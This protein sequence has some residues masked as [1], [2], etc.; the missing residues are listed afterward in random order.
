MANTKTVKV[1][2]QLDR[3]KIRYMGV[4]ILF[5]ELKSLSWK[6]KTLILILA[7]V[8]TLDTLILDYGVN[9]GHK[10]EWLWQTSYDEQSWHGWS[11]GFY[12]YWYVSKVT[13]GA[14]AF[15]GVLNVILIS[16]RKISNY[17]WG[18]L[19]CIFY[20]NYAFAAGY[21]GD[22]L[23]NI[24]FYLPMSFVGWH[25]WLKHYGKDA[26]KVNKFK[27]WYWAILAVFLA[28]TTVAWYYLIPVIDEA[29]R[30]AMFNDTSGYYFASEFWPHF[31]D[32]FTNALGVASTF[33][34]YGRFGQEFLLY[35]VKDAIGIVMWSGLFKT[36]ILGF[37]LSMIINCSA[38]FI[39]GAAGAYVWFNSTET[40]NK[41]LKT[42]LKPFGFIEK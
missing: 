36:D 5:K 22:A 35:M 21:T 6:W 39:A 19:S 25:I 1:E 29:L 41:V 40:G 42:A 31:F 14:T 38:Y 18:I 16:K 3:S 8:F 12:H 10:F 15:V 4:N 23:L 33:L 20:G 7:V 2:E 17:F 30:K 13:N 9:A 24:F 26:V 27:P 32:A 37:D 34:M 28:A 11:R